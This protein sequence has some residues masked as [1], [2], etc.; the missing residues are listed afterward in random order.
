MTEFEKNLR[1]MWSP[2]PAAI[3]TNTVSSPLLTARLCQAAWHNAGFYQ[4]RF[5]VDVGGAVRSN[6]LPNALPPR[7]EDVTA[8]ALARAA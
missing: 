3:Y 8:I 4:V 5:W 6:L 1:K 2:K 7:E